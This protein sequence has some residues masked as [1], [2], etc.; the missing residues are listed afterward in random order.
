M[1][2]EIFSSP[3][4]LHVPVLLTE[5]IDALRPRSGGRYLDGTLGLG[6]HASALLQRASLPDDARTVETAAEAD[7]GARSQQPACSGAGAE[8]CGLDRDAE[9][10]ELARERLAPFGERVHL[11]HRRYS[12]FEAALDSLGWETVDGALI[13]IG[14]SSL[15]IDCAERGF[16]FLADGPLDMRMD[17]DSGEAPVSR[18]VNRASF[19]QLKDVITRYGEDPQAGRIARCIVEER[20]RKPIETTRELAVLVERAYPPAWRARS[21][22][23]PATR[24]FQALR[25]AVNDELGELERFLAAILSRLAVGGRVAVISFHSLEDRIVKHVFRSWACGCVCPPH[26]PVCVCGHTPEARVITPKPVLPAREETAQNPRAASAKLRVAEKIAPGEAAR[27]D[28][29]QRYEA[30]RAARGRA[31]APESPPDMLRA[32]AGRGKGHVR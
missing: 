26:V 13:D 18:M 9:A 8:L 5:V 14:V 10:L 30:K 2:T 6:G 20:A 11:F 1:D 4:D 21:R 32:N 15:Q 23:H 3:P 28:R 27:D 19:E 31:G 25:M 7:A 24:T 29:R 17:R 12:E 16:S 22:N